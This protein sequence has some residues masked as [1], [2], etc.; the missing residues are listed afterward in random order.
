MVFD[1]ADFNF[2][3]SLAGWALAMI[4]AVLASLLV[5]MVAACAAFGVQRGPALAL[6]VVSRGITDLLF[7]APRRVFAMALLTFKESHRRRAFWVLAIFLALF[8]F[9]GW[10]L[11]ARNDEVPAKPYVSFVLTSMNFLLILMTLLIACWGIPADIK[12]RSLHTVVTKPVRRS[13]IVLGRML[14]YIGVI[15][16]VLLVT[17]VVG[18]FWICNQVPERAQPQ[19][20]S[21]VVQYGTTMGFKDRNGQPGPGINVGDPWEYRKYVE[22]ATKSCAEWTFENLPVERLRADKQ[23]RLEQSFEAYRTFKGDVNKQVRYNLTFINPATGLRVPWKSFPVNERKAISGGNVTGEFIQESQDP[24]VVVPAEL[25]YRDSY[26]AESVSKKVNL[27]D[28]LIVDGRLKIEVSAIEAQ[29]YVGAAPRDLFLRL[30]DRTFLSSY[31]KACIG[32]WLLLVLMIVLGTTG[33]CFLKGPVATLFTAA[34][35]FV[36]FW[37]RDSIQ[38]QV[39]LIRE[40]REVVGGGPFEAWYRLVTQ[41]N[42]SS[43][44]PDNLASD[45]LQ[46]LDQGVFKLYGVVGAVIPDVKRFNLS[47]YPANGYEIPW[48]AGL[49]P[50]ALITLAFFIPFFILGYFSLQLRELEH[51]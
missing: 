44:L 27:F 17:S 49:L 2:W 45:A 35:L 31:S 26:G 25:T 6:G 39:V 51:K 38:E 32:L 13:E 43:A 29:Q 50:C 42:P 3:G 11:G 15:S 8:M 34:L 7:I 33:S 30:T 14:G 40:R 4:A 36:G 12:A 23:L 41:A 20:I 18:Y 48:L 16:V 21:R 24:T 46:T 28:D 10:F 19:L 47:E 1:Y 22:G 5:G 37:F 9:G